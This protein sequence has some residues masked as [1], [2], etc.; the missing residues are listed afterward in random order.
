M[1]ENGITRHMVLPIES[2]SPQ[3]EPGGP[4][5]SSD[6][7]GRLE[8]P[9]PRDGLHL[10]PAVKLDSRFAWPE[11]S[12]EEAW[13]R[14]ATWGDRRQQ[15]WDA[16][17]RVA[18]A[19]ASTVR[20]AYCGSS[21]WVQ[22]NGTAG[23]GGVD[24]TKARTICNCCRHRLCAACARPAGF[25]VKEN[26]RKHLGGKTHRFLTFTLR[27]NHTPL[28]D[29]IDRLY[30]SFA[31]LRRRSEIAPALKG[32]VVILEIKISGRDGL[33]HPH[34]HVLAE[35][36]WIDQKDLSRNWYA[37]TGDSFKVDI[38]AIE[39]ADRGALYVSKYVTKPV[40]DTVYLHP[41]MLDE[42]IQALEGRKTLATFGSWRGQRVRVPAQD[43]GTPETWKTV[44]GVN[45]RDKPKD[46][47]AWVTMG[48]IASVRA[49]WER[50]LFGPMRIKRLLQGL[51]SEDRDGTP[52]EEP[53]DADDSLIPPE[54]PP[55]IITATQLTFSGMAP[56]QMPN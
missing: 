26:I 4:R 23:K 21:L 53:S 30:R 2:D 14:H 19:K 48:P 52:L 18:P 43:D 35:G 12:E 7:P 10:R 32:G 34:L 54:I 5:P 39:D 37:V 11:P 1:S 55:P 42:Y 56:I 51:P 22:H 20:F 40:D 45:L 15:T 46:D 25:T 31:A 49:Q 36:S 3:R 13:R 29:Q 44:G 28:R 47:T 24:A 17:Q 16:L 38:R 41:E 27:H 9:D 8:I 50:G 33:W 6:S